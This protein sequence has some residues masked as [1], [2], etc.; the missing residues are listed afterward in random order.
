M[1]FSPLDRIRFGGQRPSRERL[2]DDPR[3]RWLLP[4]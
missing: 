2:I 4:S 3:E 1:P